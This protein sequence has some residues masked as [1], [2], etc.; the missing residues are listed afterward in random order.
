[1]KNERYLFSRLSLQIII[2]QGP[3]PIVRLVLNAGSIIIIY[4]RVWYYE[5][6]MYQG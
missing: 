4:K 3:P 6:G 1:M 2:R 5:H